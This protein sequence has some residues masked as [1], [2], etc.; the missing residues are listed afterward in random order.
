MDYW[1]AEY[2]PF[3]LYDQADKMQEGQGDYGLG[4]AETGKHP[5]CVPLS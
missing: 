2:A 4:K 1:G 3:F 5:K